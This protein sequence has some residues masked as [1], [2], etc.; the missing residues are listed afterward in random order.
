MPSIKFINTV[1]IPRVPNIT[2]PNQSSVP[3]TTHITRTLPP[4][5]DMPCVTIRRDGTKNNSLFKLDPAGNAF[6]CPL[7]FYEPLQYNKK[8][9]VLTEEP[10]PPTDF[11]PPIPE[12]ETPEV[13]PLT[14]K[15]ECPDPKRNNPRIGDLNSAGTEK[16]VGFMYVE[17]TKECLV[18]YSPTTKVEKYLPTLNTVST[19]FAITIVATISATLATPFLNKVL[20]PLFKQIIAKLKKFSANKK[21][22]VE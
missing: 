3:N 18:L 15:P 1:S 19:T 10:K 11:T 2:I 5:F 6:I 14:E 16:V 21:N 22:K 17:E 4:V 7:P 20:K 12:T 13:P 8:D 9:L